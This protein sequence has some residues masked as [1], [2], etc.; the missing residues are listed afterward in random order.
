MTEPAAPL[1][2][3][4]PPHPPMHNKRVP[5]EVLATLV[6]VSVLA[7]TAF[8]VVSTIIGYNG[9]KTI[10]QSQRDSC[11]TGQ[12]VKVATVNSNWYLGFAVLQAPTQTKITKLIGTNY[13]TLAR[14]DAEV[15]EP[16]YAPEL[17]ANLRHLATYSCNT[18]WPSPNILGG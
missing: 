4:I 5:T 13:E 14:A 6:A 9:R 2:D 17:P 7:L 15:I 10:T 16:Q 12:K 1:A 3:H 11:Q 8:V 18:V